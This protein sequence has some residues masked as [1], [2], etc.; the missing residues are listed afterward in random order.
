TLV[1]IGYPDIASAAD[2]VPAIL[3]HQPI[4]LEA[5]DDKLI[6]FQRAKNLNPEA[7]KLLPPGGGWLMVQMGGETKEDA[8]RAADAMLE[9]LGKNRDDESVKLFDDPA[10]EKEMWLVRESG[11]GATARVPGPSR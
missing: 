4:A 3:P 7:L 2:A 5:M 6:H 9:S 1:F 11:L 8:D 10:R